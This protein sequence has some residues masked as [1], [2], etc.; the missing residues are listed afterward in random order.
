VKCGID[1]STYQGNINW[2]D[3]RSTGID[4]AMI[5]AT[6]GR[7][8]TAAYRDFTDSKF[9]ANITG[10]HSV[11]IR[12]G[13]YHYLTAQTVPEAMKEAEYFLSV[14][15]PFGKIISL[16]AAVDVESSKY[17][18]N[19]KTLLTQIVFAFCSRVEA[20]GYDPMIYTNLDW[21][22]NRLNDISAYPLWLA[23]WRDRENVPT[24]KQF[25][26]MRIWQWGTEAVKGIAGKPDANFMIAEKPKSET[27]ETDKA[28]GGK[29]DTRDNTP[30]AWAE[31]DVRWAVENK[32]MRGDEKGDLMLHQ[33]LTRE[34]ACAIA[35][36]VY[37]LL[38][39]DAADSVAQKLINALKEG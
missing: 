33:P 38:I 25:P 21:M 5:K 4:F 31:E 20:A 12:C 6:Q 16:Y 8:E 19:D 24:V 32:I 29:K 13:V 26:S 15:E 2:M 36:R 10:A 17:L 23:L 22:K 34:Q 18:P 14:I 39:E 28:V 27:V 7:S 1:V 30:S 3:V 9:T 37:D 35:K 11:G